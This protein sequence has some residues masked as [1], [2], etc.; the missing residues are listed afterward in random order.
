MSEYYLMNK[1]H[2]LM[3]FT[4]FFDETTGEYNCES[5]ETYV[6]E[7]AF[8]PKFSKIKTWIND[9]NYAKHKEHL[10]KWLKEWQIDNP[11]GFIEMT[12]ALSLNDSLW[13]KGAE[14]DLTWERVNLYENE[15]TD[16]VSRT[17]FERGLQGLKLST[18]SP[19][20]TSEGSFE[21]C[22]MRETDGIYL[23]KKSSSGFANAGLEAYSEYYST[24]FAQ[25][26]CR[27]YVEYDLVKFKG[28]LVSRCR[29]FT[30]EN[31]GFIPIYKY[32]DANERYDIYDILKFLE[33]YGFADDFRNMIV[34]DAVIFNPDRHFGNF[35]FIVNNETYEVLRFA[36]VFDHNMAMLARAMECDLVPDSPYI[37]E[38]GHKISGEFVPVARAIATDETKQK[39]K[40]MTDIELKLHEQYNLPKARTD[41]LE[42]AVRKQIRE[43]CL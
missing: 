29:M 36:P 2:T 32:L 38:M 34:L 42:N 1:N 11:I 43:I 19:E 37:A 22:W 14:S 33:P 24:Q 41:Y 5:L 3:R 26:L 12:H 15:F 30:N 4:V 23:Y 25:V 21:K 16:V 20:F 8:P 9:R 35:G 40:D 6:D 13:V 39:L 10:R 31:E 7:D 18:T 28:S 27:D 17:A